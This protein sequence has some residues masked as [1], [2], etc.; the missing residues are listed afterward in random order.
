MSN[1]TTTGANLVVDALKAVC[2]HIALFTAD[3]TDAGTLTNELA[4]SNGYSR[5]AITWSATSDE[6]EDNTAA[7][8]FTASG[9]DWS[10]ATHWGLVTSGTHGAGTMHLTGALGATRTVLDGDSLEIDVGDLVMAG[11]LV[12]A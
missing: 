8:T 11:V 12:G 2:T 6:D 7:V 10:A 5:Q 9:G 1:L 4:N 3:P